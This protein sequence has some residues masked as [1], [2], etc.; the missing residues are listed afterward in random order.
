MTAIGD[1]VEAEIA[2]ACTWLVCREPVAVAAAGIVGVLYLG[3][4]FWT[5]T[6]ARRMGRGDF[7]W[8][9]LALILPLAP[10]VYLLVAD[11]RQSASRAGPGR[12]GG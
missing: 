7:W 9:F 8:G 6:L 1:L 5:L 3:Q 4:A 11:Q 10:L 12:R 2:A